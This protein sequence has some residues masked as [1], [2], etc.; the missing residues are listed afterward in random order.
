[1]N[2]GKRSFGGVRYDLTHLDP[3]TVTVSCPKGERA[4]LTV[5]IQFGAHVFSQSW[6]VGDPE[7]MKCMDGTTARCFCPIR[8][9]HSLHLASIVER[10]LNGRVLVS[11]QRKFVL[12]GNPPG[13]AQPY[14]V[15]FLMRGLKNPPFDGAVDV[16]SAYERPH[17][18][19]MPGMAGYD[20]LDMMRA[21]KFQWPKKK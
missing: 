14:S 13:V 1:M 15:F 19:P 10:G 7:D 17:L 3:A 4:D 8:Y 20:L 18:R 12:F 21:G 9:G 16:V 6:K 2:W 5:R 11:P